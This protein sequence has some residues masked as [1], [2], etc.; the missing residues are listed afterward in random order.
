MKTY[1]RH[2]SLNVVDVKELIAL[3]YLDFEGKYKDYVEKHD[4]WEICYVESGNIELTLENEKYTLVQ[5]DIIFLPPDKTHSYF[6]AKGNKNKAFVICFECSSQVLKSL[7]GVTFSL[8][9]EQAKLIEGII[10]EYKHTFCINENDVMEL[11]PHPNFGG[12]QA[13]ILQLEYL[14]IALI[15]KLSAGQNSEIV[16]LD[17]DEFYTGLVN[18]I[19]EF[20]QKN[21]HRKLQLKD[22]CNKV[23]YSRSFVCKV[24]KEQTGESLF[25]YF[26]RLKIEEAKKLLVKT[27]NSIACISRELG[28]SEAKYFGAMFKNFVGVSPLAYKKQKMQNKNEEAKNELS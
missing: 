19:K 26:N 13:I 23:N 3:E 7:G 28:F 20:L 14:L 9:K 11:L 10:G 8:E 12:Q 27:E 5:D 16:F 6:S 21:I 1:L 24:F 4:F 22:I 2:K 17:Q 15:R 18:I 25:T